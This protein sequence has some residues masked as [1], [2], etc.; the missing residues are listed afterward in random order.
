MNFRHEILV[1]LDN[2]EQPTFQRELFFIYV[3][4][5]VHKST[6]VAW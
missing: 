5:F 4:P 1:D 3:V 2:E 6:A